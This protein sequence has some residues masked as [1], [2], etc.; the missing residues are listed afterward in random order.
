[1][2]PMNL[3]GGCRRRRERGESRSSC[4]HPQGSWLSDGLCPRSLVRLL[5]RNMRVIGSALI[6][7]PPLKEGTLIRREFDTKPLET[8]LPLPKVLKLEVLAG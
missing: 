8:T 3:A 5:A 7:Q 4:Q 2:R 6:I 1:M